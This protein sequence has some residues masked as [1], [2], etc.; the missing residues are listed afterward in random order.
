MSKLNY[1]YNSNTIFFSAIAIST[2]CSSDHWVY[3]H[4]KSEIQINN[5]KEL[6]ILIIILIVIFIFI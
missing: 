3:F 2:T 1:K 5:E 4:K 6:K